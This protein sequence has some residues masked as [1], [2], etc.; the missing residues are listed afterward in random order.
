MW[1]Y[2][3]DPKQGTLI[4]TQGKFY[5]R[6]FQEI[7]FYVLGADESTS[8]LREAQVPILD[9]AVCDSWYT[10]ITIHGV[11]MCAG[12]EVGGVDTCQ[13]DSGGP[14]VC[15]S[16]G[17]YYLQGLT[18]F[19]IGCADPQNPGVYT[20]VSDLVTWTESIFLAVANN[21]EESKCF[22]NKCI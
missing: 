22:V 1:L 4:N 16:S 6:S 13:G 19:G 9:N 2:H 5:L 15:E 14:L 8:I 10:G 7:V 20:R 18:S 17:Q 12:Y 21:G 11:M 3:D